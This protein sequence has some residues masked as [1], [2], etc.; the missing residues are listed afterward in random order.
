[1]TDLEGESELVHYRHQYATLVTSRNEVSWYYCSLVAVYKPKLWRRVTTRNSIFL[2]KYWFGFY[3]IVTCY[4]TTD[5]VR[6]DNPFI[7]K[8]SHVTTIIHNYFL[9]C[10][11][12]AQLTNTHLV[13]FL[14]TVYTP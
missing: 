3:N 6:I 9:R 14:K 11:N 7:T 12:T 2:S 1:V 5:A 4:A 8:S 13:L 10:V